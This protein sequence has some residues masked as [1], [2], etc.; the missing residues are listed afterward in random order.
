MHSGGKNK[1]SKY[2]HICMYV[3]FLNVENRNMGRDWVTLKKCDFL[4]EV[5]K[6]SHPITYHMHFAFHFNFRRKLK[7]HSSFHGI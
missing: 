2:L 6:P 1:E 4:I 3:I 5:L 7:M